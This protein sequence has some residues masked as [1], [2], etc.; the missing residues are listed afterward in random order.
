MQMSEKPST[1]TSLAGD[2]Q[3]SCNRIGWY[4]PPAKRTHSIGEVSLAHHNPIMPSH[5]NHD[6]HQPSRARISA[7]ATH[8][9]GRADREQENS[10]SAAGSSGRWGARGR[11][12]DQP[13][14][15]GRRRSWLCSW[16]QAAMT[17]RAWSRGSNRPHGSLGGLTPMECEQLHTGHNHWPNC[18]GTSLAGR[19]SWFRDL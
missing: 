6:Y 3:A 4:S 11:R 13:T 5:H 14:A 12:S 19:I 9:Q 18:G 16:H 15:R 1:E 8:L 2:H 7:T 17:S 10:R